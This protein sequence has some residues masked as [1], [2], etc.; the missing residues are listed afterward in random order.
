M[1]LLGVVGKALY[2]GNPAWT[3]PGPVHDWEV[4][5]D[6]LRSQTSFPEVKWETDSPLSAAKVLAAARQIN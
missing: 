6:P 3:H 5:R 1:R 4:L 2:G